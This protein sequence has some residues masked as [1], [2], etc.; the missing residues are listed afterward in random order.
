ME[1]SPFLMHH[2]TYGFVVLAPDHKGNSMLD[3]GE[4]PSLQ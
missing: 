2:L 3:Y 1:V 4:A